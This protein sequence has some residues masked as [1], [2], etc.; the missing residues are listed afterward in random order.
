MSHSHI[1]IP[2]PLPRRNRWTEA[3]ILA[4][5]AALAALYVVDKSYD[6]SADR[7]YS[8]AEGKILE[9]RIV[10]EH[11]SESRYGGQIFYR[12]EARTR[13][14]V[15]G[16]EQMRWLTASEPTTTRELLAAKLSS[17]PTQ[18]EVYWA[19]NHPETAK[20]RLE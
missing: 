19:P 5:F 11:T 9:T 18:C 3:V 16:Q 12:T 15:N 13:F 4:L 10:V 14:A 17:N 7:Q 20:C 6:W 8:T 1:R 2:K